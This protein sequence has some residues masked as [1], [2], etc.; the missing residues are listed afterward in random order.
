MHWVEGWIPG[1]NLTQVRGIMAV[2][3]SECFPVMIY[4]CTCKDVLSR[5]WFLKHITCDLVLNALMLLM[6]Q[7]GLLFFKKKTVR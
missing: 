1:L 5:M 3:R 6:S 4:R 2:I 7:G